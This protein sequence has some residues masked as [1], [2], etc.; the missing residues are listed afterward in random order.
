M[1]Q[2]YHPYHLWE[3][4]LAGMWQRCD[5][6]E[7]ERLLQVAIEFT[8][9]HIKYGIAMLR[10][11]VEWPVTCEHNLTSPLNQRAFIGHCAVCL[12]IGI[13]EYITRMAWAYLSKQQQD[14]ANA[15]ADRAI[16]QWTTVYESK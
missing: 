7:E 5:R 16:L 13:P 12:Q 11:I 1:T 2:I 3:D 4:Y 6:G 15:A 14:D 8:G 10:V 9:D